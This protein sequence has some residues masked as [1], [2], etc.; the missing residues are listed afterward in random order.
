MGR[1]VQLDNSPRMH[2]GPRGSAKANKTSKAQNK[3]GWGRLV[4]F[5]VALTCCQGVSAVERA[6][7]AGN[8]AFSLK[9]LQKR[10]MRKSTTQGDIMEWTCFVSVFPKCCN[11]CCGLTNCLKEKPGGL[12][13]QIK[14]SISRKGKRGAHYQEWQSSGVQAS[15]LAN[16]KER[17]DG[18]TLGRT[19]VLVVFEEIFQECLKQQ[20]SMCEFFP[21]KNLIIDALFPSFPVS[22]LTHWFELEDTSNK[23]SLT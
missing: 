19:W 20:A 6:T 16:L 3:D 10:E 22:V 8:S 18:V 2:S 5:K 12:L 11:K 21:L 15:L 1:L 23:S 17:S 7:E 9:I 14:S 13:Q 4:L